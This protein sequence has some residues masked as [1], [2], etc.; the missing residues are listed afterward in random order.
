VVA[1]TSTAKKAAIEGDG[2]LESAADEGDGGLELEWVLMQPPP[3]AAAATA[4][5]QRC[6][7]EAD[8]SLELN[9]ILIIII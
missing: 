2:G 6:G 9:Y 5:G 8:S 7:V 1:V 3:S 4:I